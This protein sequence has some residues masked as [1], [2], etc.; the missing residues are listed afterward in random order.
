MNKLGVT[1]NGEGMVRQGREGKEECLRL[2]WRAR[3]G[4]QMGEHPC[5]KGR[6]AQ[7][8][9]TI[10]VHREGCEKM[11]RKKHL[12]T[13]RSM[14]KRRMRR[15]GC[16][17]PLS[18]CAINPLRRLFFASSSSALFYRRNHRCHTL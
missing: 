10:L 8:K 1:G 12:E 16:A 18:L 7:R 11:W 4:K 13:D 2:F 3:Q 17:S 5:K 6:Y 15:L 9:K 14:I